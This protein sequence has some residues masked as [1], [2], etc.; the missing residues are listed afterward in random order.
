M[1]LTRVRI[2]GFK[3]FAD[4]TELLF[5]RG[6]GVIVGPNGSG[7]SNIAEALRWA[8]AS[9][10]PSEFRVASGI[11]VLFNGAEGR[12][13]A[14]IAE[15]ELVLEDE[16]GVAPGGRPELSIM[17]RLAR[18]G[19]STYLI[20][21]VPVRRLDVQEVLADLGLGRDS[22]AVIAQNEVDHVLL[23]RPEERRG[24]IEE[25]AGLGK[26]KR[27]RVRAR[28][29][30][31]RVERSLEEA[32]ARHADLNGRLRPLALQASAAE[33][34]AALETELGEARLQLLASAIVQTRRDRAARAQ[35]VEV[36][37]GDQDRLDAAALAL[38]RRRE[39]AEAALGALVAEQEQASR[40]VQLLDAGVERL[41]ERRQAL[42]ERRDLVVGDGERLARRGERLL[43]EAANA[44]SAAASLE[45]DVERERAALAAEDDG[46]DLEERLR[47]ATDRARVALE[48]SLEA[49][50]AQAEHEGRLAR[51][52]SE[53]MEAEQRA[54]SAR[55]RVTELGEGES[56]RAAAR[57][58]AEEAVTA[59]ERAAG[60][61]RGAL[62][63]A[64]RE[65][66]DARAAAEV[67]RTAEA[68]ALAAAAAARSAAAEARARVEEA[69]R[70]DTRDAGLGAVL[71]RLR[72]RGVAVVG[73]H[74]EP[75]EG[76]ER[77][78]AAVLAWRAAE[79]VA[80]QASEAIAV[81]ADDALE[82]A[83]LLCLDRLARREAEGPGVPLE[84]FVRCDDEAY[85]HLVAGV[86]VVDTPADLVAVRRGIA[87]LRDGRGFDADRGMAFRAGDAAERALRRRRDHD[88]ARADLTRADEV[89]RT[90]AV[91]LEERR[92]ARETAERLESD[93]RTGAEQ[94]RAA[95]VAA[96]QAIGEALRERN[97]RVR[98][99]E[100][101]AE[102]LHAAARN[103]SRRSPV[104]EAPPRSRGRWR[105]DSPT[106]RRGS[107]SGQPSTSRRTPSASRSRRRPPTGGGGG[108]GARSASSGRGS[109]RSACG[110][111]PWNR[112]D[113]QPRH[114]ARRRNWRRS[115]GTC[116]RR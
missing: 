84:R 102:R 50:R 28:Q 25:V 106:S 87:V 78:L 72:D 63:T 64:E 43:D 4:Q 65:E 42:A 75:E 36:A 88:R 14:G 11:D 90:T 62:E 73:D 101:A 95:I 2:R 53:A 31:T 24:L 58:A 79:A 69:A 57:Q 67:A 49:R 60:E 45:M 91:A 5:E 13:A 26:Y 29:K 82:G 74:L 114:G 56:E 35:D 99:D 3:S 71:G 1:R 52:R 19:E 77:A 30:L 20:N 110:R 51:V 7:K 111:R 34:A 86:V 22:H 68:E 104:P 27:R 55:A 17:R 23:S 116:P 16:G 48:A 108:P 81:L 70:R 96:E 89:E 92:T 21:R 66:A 115:P 112:S 105:R 39:V 85:G 46:A 15:V 113:R 107:P 40:V 103:K 61:A 10:A 98:D 12:S 54:E 97:R 41:V 76:Y 44:S 109:R 80:S 32:R 93:A 37:R 6:V 9:A 100:S 8:M 59:T 38:V 83:A 33:R 18:D 47:V 94:A